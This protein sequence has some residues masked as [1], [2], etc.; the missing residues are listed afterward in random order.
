MSGHLGLPTL[1]EGEGFKTA[2]PK[3]VDRPPKS[4]M[5]AGEMV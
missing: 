3:G 5:I 2:K 4:T 1:D